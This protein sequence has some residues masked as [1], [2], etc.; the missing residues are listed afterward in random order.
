MIEAASKVI[1][2]ADSSKIGRTSFTSLGGIEL[3]H[4]LVTDDGLAIDDRRKFEK[5]G[6]EVIVA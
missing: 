3:I 1:L 2:V 5:A 4:T 6:I